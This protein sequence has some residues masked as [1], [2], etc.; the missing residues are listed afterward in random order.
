M[1]R[2]SRGQRLQGRVALAMATSSKEAGGQ[3]RRVSTKGATVR[4]LVMASERS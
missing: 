2:E 1:R 3:V 4:L